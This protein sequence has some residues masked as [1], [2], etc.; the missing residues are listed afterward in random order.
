MVPVPPSKAIF[1]GFAQAS[2]FAGL[3]GLCAGPKKA[4]PRPRPVSACGPAIFDM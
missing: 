1:A 4:T 3:P 2:G